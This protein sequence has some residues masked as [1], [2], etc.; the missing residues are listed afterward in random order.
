MA[1]GERERTFQLQRRGRYVEFNLLHDRGTKYG[2]QSGRRVESVL[3]SFPPMVSWSSPQIEELGTP[4]EVLTSFFLKPRDWLSFRLGFFR[5]ELH[6][7]FPCIRPEIVNPNL[8][9]R[10]YQLASPKSPAHLS[11]D[12]LEYRPLLSLSSLSLSENA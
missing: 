8:D 4:E 6:L 9:L 1:F 10:S 3:S 5:S 2:L 12:L 11:C 7:R